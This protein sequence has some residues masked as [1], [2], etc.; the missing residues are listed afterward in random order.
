MAGIPSVSL[1][2][3]KGYIPGVANDLFSMTPDKLLKAIFSGKSVS[4]HM[5]VQKCP[6]KLKKISLQI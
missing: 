3:L 2:K 4:G 6:R 5:I 1:G